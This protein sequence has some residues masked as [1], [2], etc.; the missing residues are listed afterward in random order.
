M[1]PELIW[2]D[3]IHEQEGYHFGKT[4]LEVVVDVTRSLPLINRNFN[5]A[6]Q[7]AYG[8]IG[9]ECKSTLVARW[10][11]EGLLAKIQD[12][13]APLTLL[14]ENFQLSFV[15]P[16]NTVYTRKA[17]IHRIS[18]SVARCID[19]SETPAVILHG[20]MLLT[21]VMAGTIKI[22]NHI[23]VPDLNAAID[24]PNSTEG[25]K[26]ASFMRASASAEW[27]AIAVPDDWA[28]YFWNRN[29]SL[30]KCYIRWEK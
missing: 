11:Q 13:L 5:F 24:A 8:H 4:T 23:Q 18:R 17:L 27:A 22:F 9:A 29:A 20:S 1:L 26:A 21:R 10:K 30:S 14:Y 19:K 3:L 7:T 16:P 2:L 15:G 28:R 25:K 12:C 6:L